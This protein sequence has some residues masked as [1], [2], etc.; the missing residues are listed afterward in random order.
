M[1]AMRMVAASSAGEVGAAVVDVG[2]AFSQNGYSCHFRQERYHCVA[3]DKFEGTKGGVRRFVQTR[4]A[5]WQ[6]SNI[7]FGWCGCRRRR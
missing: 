1:V 7:R 4:W 3:A 5:D 2:S 6:G